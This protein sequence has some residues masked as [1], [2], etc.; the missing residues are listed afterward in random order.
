M[1]VRGYPP[2][3]NASGDYGSTFMLRQRLPRLGSYGKNRNSPWR[4]TRF[5]FT[6]LRRLTIGSASP[7]WQISCGGTVPACHTIF[8][9]WKIA[10]CYG[11]KAAIL[12]AAASS[13]YWNPRASRPSRT[14]PR[15]TQGWSKSNS[16]MVSRRSS[17][18]SSVMSS[19]H[20][21]A[22]LTRRAQSSPNPPEHD[23]ASPSPPGSPGSGLPYID[24]RLAHSIG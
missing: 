13:P 6:S 20:W 24:S 12:M 11:G 5:L 23:R 9:V 7:R 1:K 8:A 15:D 16:S 21:R 22:R 4:I 19:K 3:N 18:N 14:Q 2:S 10:A 17:A